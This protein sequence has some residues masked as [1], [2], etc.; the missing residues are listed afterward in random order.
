MLLGAATGRT[1]TATPAANGGARLLPVDY[2]NKYFRTTHIDLPNVRLVRVE[3]RRGGRPE[4]LGS[5][6]AGGVAMPLVL[7]DSVAVFLQHSFEIMLGKRIAVPLAGE[8][9]I[10]LGIEQFEIVPSKNP[11]CA[12][13]DARLAVTRLDGAAPAEL[14][15]IQAAEC[16]SWV[17]SEEG[18]RAT[19]L[20]RSTAALAQGLAD[21][22]LALA[23]GAAAPTAAPTGRP[24]V[25]AVYVSPTRPVSYGGGYGGY[26]GFA[27]GSMH[28]A[29]GGFVWAG[30]ESRIWFHGGSGV[31]LACG[32]LGDKGPVQTLQTDLQYEFADVSILALAFEA[33]Y[34]LRF[35][36]GS[37]RPA[38]FPYLGIG[39]DWYIGSE[40]INVR[41]TDGFDYFEAEETTWR[42]SVAAHALAG[43]E[44]AVTRR[45][46]V[47]LEARWT[48]GGNGWSSHGTPEPG[49]IEE[50]ADQIF[51]YLVRPTDFNFTGWGARLLLN[52]RI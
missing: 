1:Q 51:H 40:K 42:S 31:S 7:A 17:F 49:S 35:R 6:Q 14:G 32:L 18:A 25:K 5:I 44:F 10:A 50:M 38:W 13:L 21:A 46:V 27:P 26:V 3:D 12:R 47:V 8:M 4:V 33:S 37:E 39:G 34:L 23:G 43:A 45:G 22:Q 52:V 24:T 36:R 29:F 11:Q 41:I 19:A 16:E 28:D 2:D 30:G 15:W 9:P 20:Y 48:Q